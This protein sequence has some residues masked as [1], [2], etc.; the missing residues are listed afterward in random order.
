MFGAGARSLRQRLRTE[1]PRGAHVDEQAT[2]ARNFH[3]PDS[4][5]GADGHDYL[6]GYDRTLRRGE[7]YRRDKKRCWKCGELIPWQ[8][9]EMHHLKGGQWGR[10]DCLH[11]L[12][13]SCK[14]DHIPAEHVQVGG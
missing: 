4:F 13:W 1:L 6:S 12:V 2:E 7:V 14:E 5:V 8:Y 10:C 11:N 3:D 9:G